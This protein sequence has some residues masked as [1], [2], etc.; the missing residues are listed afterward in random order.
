MSTASLNRNVIL[1]Y[2]AWIFTVLFLYYPATIKQKNYTSDMWLSQCIM[3]ILKTSVVHSFL[4][5]IVGLNE[6][7]WEHPLWFRTPLKMDFGYSLRLSLAI[8]CKL[9]SL[10][11]LYTR[12]YGALWDWMSAFENTPFE[13]IGGNFGYSYG[14]SCVKKT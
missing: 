4:R 3:G 2:Y 10:H 7:T 14:V 5:C 12:Y 9:C 8:E 6:C 13:G 1:C 11:W